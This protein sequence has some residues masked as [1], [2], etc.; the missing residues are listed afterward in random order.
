[1]VGG[2]V[3]PVRITAE[4]W[5]GD[6]HVGR[7]GVNTLTNRSVRIKSAQRLRGPAGARGADAA[8]TAADAGGGGG[9]S[10]GAD[11]H[12]KGGATGGKNGGKGGAER[13]AGLRAQ[14]KADQENARMRDEREASP[15]SSSPSGP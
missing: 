10:P 4:K 7:V 1:K 5:Q 13:A 14:A 15:G 8:A 11:A 12:A 2:A 3:V 9:A 6:K